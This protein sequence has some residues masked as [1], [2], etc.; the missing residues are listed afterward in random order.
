M[1][2]SSEIRVETLQ[3]AQ[4]RTPGSKPAYVA[5]LFKGTLTKWPE[6]RLK[7]SGGSFLA[8]E[9]ERSLVMLGVPPGKI[10]RLTIDASNLFS[11]PSS[12][13]PFG[14][15]LIRPVNSVVQQPASLSPYR[16]EPRCELV[17]SL[18]FFVTD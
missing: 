13:S 15:P 8:S 18:I 7:I 6:A 4:N 9:V 10:E 17:V 14:T 16:S 11:L 1:D 2:E 12:P 5:A 3:E